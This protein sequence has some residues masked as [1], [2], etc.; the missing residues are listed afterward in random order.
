MRRLL[1]SIVLVLVLA[2]VPSRAPAAVDCVRAVA[3][4]DLQNATI[5][6]LQAAMAA[7]QIT[8]ADL[9]DAYLARI[10]AYDGRLNAIRVL[11]PDARAQAERLDAER[12]AGHV[13][14]PLHG[15]PI[16]VKD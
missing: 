7:G 2:A 12:A 8:S 15:I 13:R 10:A 16:L 1:A 6:E 5:P 3:G 4:I 9:V 14:G 11:A